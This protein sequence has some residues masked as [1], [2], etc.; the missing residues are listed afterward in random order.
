MKRTR[1]WI[2]TALATTVGCGQQPNPNEAN[3]PGAP[4][5]SAPA[6]PAPPPDSGSGLPGSPR[7]DGS[8]LPSTYPGMD[9]HRQGTA[10]D[11]AEETKPAGESK[12]QPKIEEAAT[13]KD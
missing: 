7:G 11:K 13:K 10:Q 4:N 9:A 2:A 3:F 6:P 1:W 8:S 5:S 12:S